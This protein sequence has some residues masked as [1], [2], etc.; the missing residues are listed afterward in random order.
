MKGMEN[1]APLPGTAGMLFA[2]PG[3]TRAL[4]RA[5][6]WSATPLGTVDT[7]PLSL[8]T[9]VAT[10]LASKQP[11]FLWVGTGVRSTL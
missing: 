2:G 6:D 8:R 9:I 11:M 10:L 7:W 5:F 3:E 4:L 1:E